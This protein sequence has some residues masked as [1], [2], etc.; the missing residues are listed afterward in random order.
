MFSLVSCS[1]AIFVAP[2]EKSDREI[3]P[4][5]SVQKRSEV[6]KASEKPTLS[7]FSALLFL[8]VFPSS[9]VF[10]VARA[11]L[12]HGIVAAASRATL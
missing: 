10:A 9:F 6:K 1:Y 8:D 5:S 12:L 11:D 4:T 2:N 3:F 7:Y